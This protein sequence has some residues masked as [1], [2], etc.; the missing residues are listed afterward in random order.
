[1][2]RTKTLRN[3]SK[4]NSTLAVEIWRVKSLRFLYRSDPGVHRKALPLFLSVRFQ[5][6]E[7]DVMQL[8]GLG[9]SKALSLYLCVNFLT[10]YFFLITNS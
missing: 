9:P 3:D 10:S 6:N 8:H 2:K 7:K 5:Q 4:S 1:M